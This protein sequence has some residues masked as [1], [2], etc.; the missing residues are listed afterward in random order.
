MTRSGNIDYATLYFKYKNPTPINGEPTYKS[1]KRLKTELR[2]NASSVDTDLGGGDHGYLGLV[3]S[4]VEYTRINPTPAAFVAPNFPGAL[5]I[6]PAFTAIQAVQARESHAE[7]M[8]LYR[9][10]KNVEKALLRHIQTA[11]ED[12]F[13]EVM[14]D[15][16]TGLIEDDIPTVLDY[17][18]SNYGKV[19]SVEV[20][21]QES[22]V[23]NLQFNPADPMITI[24]RPI[25]QLQ[26]K[27]VEADIPY[28]EE[29]LLE[30]GL[31]LVRNT[32]DFEKAIGEWNAEP[33]K[34]WALFKTH[35]RNAQ[36]ELK[37]IRGP[38]MQQAGYHH[39]NMLASQLRVD[40]NNQQTEMLAL[41]QDLVVPEQE[42]AP[43][44]QAAN[45]TIGANVQL[46]MLQ[47]L[48][49]M[50]AA[51]AT[52][53]QHGNGGG[54]PNGGGNRN[55]GGRARI[56]RRTPD[57]ATFNRSD[58]T[59]YCHTHGACNHT[60]ADCNRKAP[61]HRNTATLANRMGGSN[62]FCQPAAEE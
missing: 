47:I 61:G 34:T 59:N 56:N 53:Q 13:L 18:F 26:K 35:F 21:E 33:T 20:K 23:L 22:E 60:S 45:A 2:A 27:A 38:T 30:F 3:L 55:G 7:D 37:D 41:M 32:R 36:T 29:Q 31:T 11:V 17:L 39:A 48:Q 57:N 12:K 54:N 16:D 25:E 46:Q 6:D 49:A 51:Q 14:V 62:A 50:Q 15:D 28:S 43:V 19:T 10:C 4:D 40:L 5:V 42:E 44:Q 52:G 24:F 1:L 8:A 9:E 58:T